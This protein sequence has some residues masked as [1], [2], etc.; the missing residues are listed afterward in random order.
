L[1]SERITLEAYRSWLA[2]YS[3]QQEIYRRYLDF[4]VEHEMFAAGESL[5]A[6]YAA[7]G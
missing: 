2:R 4:L 5:L 7:F 1:L 6:D 3:D